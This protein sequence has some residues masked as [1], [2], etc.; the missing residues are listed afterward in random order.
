MGG[1]LVSKRNDRLQELFEDG[2][3][4]LLFSS[5]EELLDHMLFI[6]KNPDKVKRIRDAGRKKVLTS[7]SIFHRTEYALKIISNHLQTA[8]KK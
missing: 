2:K 4:V 6:E 5:K 3:E 1:L 7:H 8:A